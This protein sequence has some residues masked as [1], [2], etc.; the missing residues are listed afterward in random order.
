MSLVVLLFFT[1]NYSFR[2]DI[3]N[4][5]KNLLADTI[6]ER[7]NKEIKMAEGCLVSFDSVMNHYTMF[8][9]IINLG[10]ESGKFKEGEKLFDSF[11]YQQIPQKDILK[12]ICNKL[13]Y[14]EINWLDS[15]GNLQYGW[16]KSSQNNIHGNYKDR[17]YFKKIKN[18]GTI[19]L[20]TRPDGS[21]AL[22]QVIS[23]TPAASGQLL[24]EN[25]R[26]MLWLIRKKEQRLWLY[27]L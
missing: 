6:A 1:Y 12:N 21:F 20:G 16:T 3:E 26:L 2:P 8:Y 14:F 23:R 24:A 7:F 18:G 27:L 4:S 9:D 5:S 19:S 15:N 13:E 22:D 11:P 10:T 17:T 25:L